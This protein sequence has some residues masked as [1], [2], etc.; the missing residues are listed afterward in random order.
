MMW[1]DLSKQAFHLYRLRSL[2]FCIS[3]ILGLV[4]Q[5]GVKIPA[6]IQIEKFP[7]QFALLLFLKIVH[8]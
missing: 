3:S 4:L 7:Y 2:L 5:T 1:L 8:G 6:F